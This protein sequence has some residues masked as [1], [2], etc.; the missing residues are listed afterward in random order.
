MINV[1][2]ILFFLVL[3]VLMT[4]CKNNIENFMD[5]TDMVEFKRLDDS[6][7][8]KFRTNYTYN[9]YDNDINFLFRN[10]N[11][12]RISIPFNHY[13][14]LIYKYDDKKQSGF[15][16]TM[17]L[18]EGEYDI[19]KIYNKDK[20]LDQI[21]INNYGGFNSEYMYRPRYFFPYYSYRTLI[22]PRINHNRKYYNRHHYY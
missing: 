12:I 6:L 5:M 10:D 2:V 9:L 8:K 7:I 21:I 18:T 4:Y 14:K 16:K 22:Y 11:V 19:K 15:A 20:I 13:V 1:K 17:E 3:L